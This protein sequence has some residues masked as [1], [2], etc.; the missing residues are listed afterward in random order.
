MAAGSGRITSMR[1]R[2]ASRPGCTPSCRRCATDSRRS[3]RRNIRAATSSPATASI[4]RAAMGW[5]PASIHCCRRATH[6]CRAR[7]WSPPWRAPRTPSRSGHA[8]RRRFTRRGRLSH[9]CRHGHSRCAHQRIPRAAGIVRPPA[10]DLPGRA[11]FD[12]RRGGATRSRPTMPRGC[13]WRR[14]I[15]LTSPAACS[16]PPMRRAAVRRSISRRRI[17]WFVPREAPRPSTP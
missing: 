5:P 8:A 10:C 14:P 2:R 13:R 7:C 12:L 15:R 16:P 3:I 11:R 4:Y 6:C 9:F 17:S 1:W